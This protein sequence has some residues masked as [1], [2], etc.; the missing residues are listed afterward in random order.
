VLAGDLGTDAGEENPSTLPFT[1]LPLLP[2]MAVAVLM[3]F[4]GIGV[5]RAV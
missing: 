4:A 3:V 1:G 2:L 5:R